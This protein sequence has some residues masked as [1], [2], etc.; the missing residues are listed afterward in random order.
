[1]VDDVNVYKL[2]HMKRWGNTTS[3]TQWRSECEGVLQ[4][5]KKRNENYLQ[6]VKN[7][8]GI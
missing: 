6:I 1:M 8:L 7:T 2:N 5:I 3:Y 4:Y